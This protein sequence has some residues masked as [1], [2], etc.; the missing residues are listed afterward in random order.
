MRLENNT[1]LITG[2][3]AGIGLAFAK[4]FLRLGNEV[5]ITGRNLKKLNAAKKANAG[6]NIFQCDVAD[7]KAITQLSRNVKKKFPL[8]NVVMNNAGT[9]LFKNL[10]YPAK[11]LEKL[12]SELDINIAGTIR[13]NSAFINQIKEN[14][15]S[16]INVTSALA[17]VPLQCGPIYC[18]TKAALHSYTISLRQQLADYNV[19]VIEL[20]P[21][22]VK[23][24]LTAELP[25]DGDFKMITTDEL[26]ETTIKALQANKLEI[27]PGQA[28]QLKFMSRLAPGFINA[29][30]AKGGKQLIP[31]PE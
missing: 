12:T 29:Q 21:P 28:S 13:T 6:L 31:Q 9:F 24:E 1:I 2:G 15:G 16:I 11:N 20:M 4:E 10:A 23:T 5:I 19:E 8:L 3:S 14:Q 26:V 27:T 25:E 30:L 17:F 18:A 7:S 22:A